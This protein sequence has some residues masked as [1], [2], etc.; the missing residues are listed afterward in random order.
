[1]PDICPK[2]I[3][4]ISRF[5]A[6]CLFFLAAANPAIG[7]T[8]SSCVGVNGAQIEHT[9]AGTY[10]DTIIIVALADEDL[11]TLTKTVTHMGNGNT[12]IVVTDPSGTEI[13]NETYNGDHTGSHTYDPSGDM[14]NAQYDIETDIP[15]GDDTQVL[16]VFSCTQNGGTVTQAFLKER[17]NLLI[18]REPD[19]PRMVRKRL[20]ALWGESN[21]DN[22]NPDSINPQASRL[23]VSQNNI[24]TNF[25][26]RDSTY[27]DNGTK[28]PE[29]ADSEMGCW[30]LWGETHYTHYSD[31][32]SRSGD[33]AVGYLGIDC[34]IH[35]STIAGVLVQVDWMDDKIGSA[36]SASNGTGWMVGPYATVRLTPN[37][38]FD[39]RAAWGRSDNDVSI[40]GVTGDF[41][42]ERWLVHARLSGN[43][44]VDDYRV[45]PEA[46]LS[47]IEEAQDSFMN[48]A[49]N[50]VAAYTA[51]L[52]RLKFGPEIAKRILTSSGDYA[53]PFVSLNGVWDFDST[54]VTVANSSYSNSLRGMVKAGIIYRKPNGINFRLAVKYD[55]IGSG[56]YSA[57]G[58]EFWLNIP[59]Y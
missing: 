45:T 10:N 18:D 33:F 6:I 56:S 19:R 39:I 31:A 43:F 32:G 7:Q 22:E 15:V 58:G 21:T 57:Y 36:D 59:L 3:A 29:L 9:G 23:F 53:E 42:T 47:Y 52:G 26:L 17:M 24:K 12:R 38:Y 11:V 49:G 30:D 37:M 20:G 14:V 50:N 16:Y 5:G 28:D 1:M 44:Y 13:V 51:S 8:Y 40:A 54:N 48:S 41:E 55:G 35:A 27:Y 2:I 25:S 34:Q 46:S 4:Y